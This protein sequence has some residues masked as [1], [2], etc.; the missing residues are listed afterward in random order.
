MTGRGAVAGGVAAIRASAVT[1]AEA[2][3][4]FLSSPRAASP[5]TLRAYAG[6]IDRLAA[7]LGR[8]GSSP[9]CR[10]MRSPPRCR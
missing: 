6:V 5:N 3:D 9:P 2:A 7:E 10:T 4:A 8:T 1:V